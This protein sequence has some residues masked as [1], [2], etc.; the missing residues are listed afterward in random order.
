[1]QAP[2]ELRPVVSA[3]TLTAE[4]VRA[5][6]IEFAAASLDAVGRGRGGRS[7]V[8]SARVRFASMWNLRGRSPRLTSAS[9]TEEHVSLLLLEFLQECRRAMGAPSATPA[10]RSRARARLAHSWNAWRKRG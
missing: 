7:G 8:V 1:M 5:V 6:A 3:D 10:E 2:R 9:L 4:H